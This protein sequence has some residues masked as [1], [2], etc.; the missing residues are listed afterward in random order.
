M[1]LDPGLQSGIKDPAPKKGSLQDII[2]S[3]VKGGSS[4]PPPTSAKSTNA[5]Q[6]AIGMFKKYGPNWI[7]SGYYQTVLS[8]A[9]LYGVP[10]P[11]LAALFLT[12]NRGADPGVKNSTSDATGLA[13]ILDGTLLNFNK[14]KTLTWG[15]GNTLGTGAV[16]TPAMKKNP[17]FAIAYAAWRLAG[18]M[19]TYGNFRDAYMKG[20]HGGNNA[21]DP[22]K[23]LGNYTPSKTDW[24]ASPLNKKY[25]GQPVSHVGD[26]YVIVD[27][28]TGKI[29]TTI[30]PA[31][32]NILEFEGFPQTMS[33]LKQQVQDK[34][35]LGGDF[36]SLTGKSPNINIVAA[37]M[38]SGKTTQQIENMLIDS[39][40]FMTSPTGKKYSLSYQG[41]YNGIMGQNAKLPTGDKAKGVKSWAEIVK[42]AAKNNLTTDEFATKLRSSPGYL[43]SNE[44]K[45][46][47][48]SFSDSYQKIYG[49]MDENAKRLASDA[50]LAGWNGDQWGH[51][52]RS[53]PA[54]VKTPEYKSHA[55]DILDKLGMTFG[56]LPSLSQGAGTTPTPGSLGAA[57]KAPNSDKRIPGVVGSPVPSDATQ[58]LG[59]TY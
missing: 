15:Q 11:Y 18:Q 44:F 29:T 40:Y 5:D 41:V 33:T 39:K 22:T 43:D 37:L 3:L 51:Y 13:Q 4:P 9:H 24:Q 27:K 25:A 6:I 21:P 10:A 46:N 47:K 2:D 14:G 20:Y 34:N 19:D 36:Y 38:G 30:D 35:G 12:E 56:F 26:P 16:I 58:G 1:A 7:K 55:L 17:V 45:Q 32:K 53:Q 50:A 52:L 59:V 31:N 8:Y 49:P 23:L 28:K 57:D 42:D 54:Y 48:T